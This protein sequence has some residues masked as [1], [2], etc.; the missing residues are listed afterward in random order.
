[1]RMD[2]TVTVPTFSS[3]VGSPADDGA[4]SGTK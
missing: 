4:P 3:T 1:V 2:S